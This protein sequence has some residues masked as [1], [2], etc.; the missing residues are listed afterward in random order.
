MTRVFPRALGL[1][2]IAVF[3]VVGAYAQPTVGLTIT[4]ANPDGYNLGG[5]YTN[6]YTFSVDNNG[7]ITY[8][9]LL[10]CDDFFNDVSLGESW[11]AYETSLTS[12]ENET[13]INHTVYFSS[14]TGG[15]SQTN[16]SVAAQIAGYKEVAYL[17]ADLYYNYSQNNFGNVGAA[18]L[19]Y[20][21]WDIFDPSLLAN[22]TQGLD[23]TDLNAALAD[24]QTAQTFVADGGVVGNVNIYTPSCGPST[25]CT[26]SSNGAPQE[27]IQV[28]SNNQGLPMPEPAMPAVLL[29]DLGFVLAAVLF[30]R[31]RSSVRS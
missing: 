29:V 7:S 21:I 19:S 18:Q 17:A 30:L 16:P 25:P 2:A 1:L 20:A 9:V 11:N 6:P 28:L 24:V 27:F 12:I 4:N 22:N 10:S 15:V 23:T 8:P 13:S 3:F 5:I 31:R 14:F 26:P